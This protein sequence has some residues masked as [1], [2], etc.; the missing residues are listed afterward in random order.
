MKKRIIIPGDELTRETRRE[1]ICGME[2]EGT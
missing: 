2:M 1:S